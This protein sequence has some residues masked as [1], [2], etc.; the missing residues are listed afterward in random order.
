LKN[1]SKIDD[2]FASRAVTP[3]LTTT[4]APLRQIGKVAVRNVLAMI[5]GAHPTANEPL[6]VPTHLIIRDSTGQARRTRHPR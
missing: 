5:N 6:V 3:A 4:A 1:T 2:I